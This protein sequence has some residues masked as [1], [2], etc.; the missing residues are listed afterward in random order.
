MPDISNDEIANT[1]RCLAHR[2]L[3]AILETSCLTLVR[4]P[5]EPEEGRMYVFV[6][7]NFDMS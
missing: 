7:V 1:P 5:H 3:D 6:H 2:M 4:H